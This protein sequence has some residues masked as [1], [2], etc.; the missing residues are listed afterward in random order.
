MKKTVF[1]GGT[2]DPVHN[3]HLALA[4]EILKSGKFDRILFVPASVLP[5]SYKSGE[6][7]TAFCHRYAMLERAVAGIDGF[8]LSDIE[9]RRSGRS[10]T[11]D[12]LREL[13]SQG[14][15]GELTLLMGE[16]SLMKLHTWKEA[17]A[18]VREF[19]ILVYPRKGGSL[20]AEKLA[21]HWNREE[22]GKLLDSCQ[23]D[24]PE[25]DIS[26]TRIRELMRKGD[27]K[28]LLPFVKKEV[29]DYIMEE[30]LY[31]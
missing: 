15:W 4:G 13:R 18:L 10:Y 30:K 2:F 29:L 12:T 14:I 24:M 17:H 25:F 28:A 8:A 21:A 5:H 22:T 31:L 11:V 16:D 27:K 26:S 1:F 6:N 20:S 3:G 19:Q 9:N 23:M 7:V